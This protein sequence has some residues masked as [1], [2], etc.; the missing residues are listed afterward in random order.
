LD[1]VL[2]MRANLENERAAASGDADQ[3]SRSKLGSATSKPTRRIIAAGALAAVA[4][5]GL[6]LLSG[7]GAKG[8]SG[9]QPLRLSQKESAERIDAWSWPDMKQL[10]VEEIAPSEL[11]RAILALGL[12]HA[13]AN[14]LKFDLD[15]GTRR[16]GF[17]YAW[18]P[19]G[20]RGARASFSTHG[21]TTAVE[22]TSAPAKVYVLLSKAGTETLMLVDTLSR[23]MSVGIGFRNGQL[24]TPFR[25]APDNF[26]KSVW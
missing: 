4:V 3:N 12:G 24:V 10:A 1:E 11:E 22:L 18:D 6:A 13:A 23:Q 26:R 2:I 25:E 19:D 9:P 21:N 16:I 14:A 5:G 7:K 15:D 8:S 20:D 17:F